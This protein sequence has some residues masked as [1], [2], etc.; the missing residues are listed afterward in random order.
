M[1]FFR[2]PPAHDLTYSDV[3]LMPQR[4]EVGSRLAVDLAVDDP[5]GLRTPIVAANMTSERWGIRKTSL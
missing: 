5:T 2:E 3:F 1:R 4:S